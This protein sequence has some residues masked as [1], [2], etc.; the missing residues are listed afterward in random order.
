MEF[1]YS[2]SYFQ[3]ILAYS[4]LTTKY[5]FSD[6]NGIQ[7]ALLLTWDRRDLQQV[8][9]QLNGWTPRWDDGMA[10]LPSGM[11]V[12]TS[13]LSSFIPQESGRVGLITGKCLEQGVFSHSM[14]III[15]ALKYSDEKK[16]KNG[17][18]VSVTKRG[19]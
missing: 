15:F 7:A 13:A 8:T 1:N 14:M 10:E 16:K 19:P 5:W 11:T 18:F 3:K 4:N 2:L 17:G 6:H 9:E 12:T